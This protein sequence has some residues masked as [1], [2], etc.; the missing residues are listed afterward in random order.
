M[1]SLSSLVEI[2]GSSE[3]GRGFRAERPVER[4]TSPEVYAPHFVVEGDGFFV[5]WQMEDAALQVKA[6]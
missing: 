4:S 1:A 5:E 3:A 2:T 6:S